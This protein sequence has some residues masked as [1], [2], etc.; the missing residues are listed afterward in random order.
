MGTF[1]AIGKRV[2]VSRFCVWNFSGRNTKREVYNFAPEARWRNTKPETRSCILRCEAQ[3][4]TRTPKHEVYNFAP[5]L[6]D[7]TRSAKCP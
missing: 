6:G 3:G 1:L 7:E 4:E 2:R 5:K